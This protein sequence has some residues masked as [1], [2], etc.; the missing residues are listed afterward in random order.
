MIA[1]TYQFV[2]MDSHVL[3]KRSPITKDFRARLKVALE[4]SRLRRYAQSVTSSTANASVYFNSLKVRDTSNWVDWVSLSLLT[5]E[6]K[7]A[8]SI[9]G[10][11]DQLFLLFA[12]I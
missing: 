1:V 3:F 4:N 5:N 7:R 12:L 2:P 9:F 8:F 10:W 11:L 6:L